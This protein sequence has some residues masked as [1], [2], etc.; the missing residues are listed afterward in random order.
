MINKRIETA[1]NKQIV[2]EFLSGYL[3]LSMSAYFA[4]KNLSGFAHWTYVQYQEENSHAKKFFDYINAQ[5][6]CVTLEEIN[7][8]K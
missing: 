4:H 6:G 2:E 8:T 3:Y 5:G 7:I 1:L